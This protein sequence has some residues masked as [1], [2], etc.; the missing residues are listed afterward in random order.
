MKKK[1]PGVRIANP[2]GKYNGDINPSLNSTNFI[3]NV[4]IPKNSRAREQK[5]EKGFLYS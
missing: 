1:T 3:V 4:L 5:E 2:Q